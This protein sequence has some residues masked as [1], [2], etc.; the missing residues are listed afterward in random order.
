MFELGRWGKAIHKR[1]NKRP[2][3]DFLPISIISLR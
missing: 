2:T 3:V 1:D